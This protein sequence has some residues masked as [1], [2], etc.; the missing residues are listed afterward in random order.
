MGSPFAGFK[1]YKLRWE[2]E[3]RG[4][5]AGTLKGG[6]TYLALEHGRSDSTLFILTVLIPITII[7]IV[8]DKGEIL[9]QNKYRSPDSILYTEEGYSGNTYVWIHD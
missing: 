2:G 6:D 8:N 9:K 1:G 5:Q 3:S 7:P 4:R